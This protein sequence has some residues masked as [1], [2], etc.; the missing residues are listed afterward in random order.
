MSSGSCT[1]TP[2]PPSIKPSEHSQS[3]LRGVQIPSTATPLPPPSSSSISG[4]TATAQGSG[5]RRDS[6]GDQSIK[7][8][9][10][11]TSA[12]QAAAAAVA[13][14][15]RYCYF[16]SA[17]SAA[18]SVSRN[19]SLSRNSVYLTSP[20]QGQ[21][22]NSPNCTQPRSRP[23]NGYSDATASSSSLFLLGPHPPQIQ[24]QF[25]EN[26][27]L[28]PPSSTLNIA[29]QTTEE[30]DSEE[31]LLRRD[32]MDAVM[33]ER[34]DSG[35]GGSVS[36][37]SSLAAFGR[38]IRKVF[39]KTSAKGSIE[40]VVISDPPVLDYG[41]PQDVLDHESWAQ[42]LAQRLTLASGPDAVTAW[43]GQLS[44]EGTEETSGIAL[45]EENVSI[46][47]GSGNDSINGTLISATMM[48]VPEG[49]ASSESM[50]DMIEEVFFTIPASVPMM[51][52]P[53]VAPSP[54]ASVTELNVSRPLPPTKSATVPAP[55][56]KTLRPVLSIEQLNK[57]QPP[58]P[59]GSLVKPA[60][61]Q[62]SRSSASTS[63]FNS[64]ARKFTAA[65]FGFRKGSNSKQNETTDPKLLHETATASTTS[66][67]A[68]NGLARDGNINNV[69]LMTS[70]DEVEG[71]SYLSVKPVSK[72]T[73]RFFKSLTTSVANEMKNSSRPHEVR[74]L[75]E[76]LLSHSNLSPEEIS[77]E[78]VTASRSS[79]LRSPPLRRAAL[80]QWEQPS[81]AV[82]AV[83]TDSILAPPEPQFYSK[84]RAV[85][86]SSLGESSSCGSVE[87]TDDWDSLTQT[88][89]NHSQAQNARYNADL[90]GLQAL[91]SQPLENRPS[92]P[93]SFLTHSTNTS[94]G[95]LTLPLAPESPGSKDITVTVKSTSKKDD[96]MCHRISGVSPKVLPVS[97]KS[98]PKKS[99][100][101]MTY[102]GG[103]L[104]VVK[105]A[106]VRLCF[107]CYNHP[108]SVFLLQRQW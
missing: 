41:I 47:H 49:S 57:P 40:S 29:L 96:Y 107:V 31:V 78:I 68:T 13:P 14:Q 70:P 102:G 46:T 74:P 89:V 103:E 104:E 4:N 94:T 66:L 92:R 7:S 88:M 39:W 27:P 2:P 90:K 81:P 71:A 50:L 85:S 6:Q 105:S 10:T 25:L 87:S 5:R 64:I 45:V 9:S 30:I 19:P 80:P 59:A 98:K 93:H 8:T 61:N 43:L 84:G 24:L 101:S 38:G 97:G 76:V 54:M 55:A 82:S 58:I 77:A 34:K 23:L 33:V 63:P 79:S 32:S 3:A 67:R 44:A 26:E 56:A 12:G 22:V 86:A 51:P 1:Y 21:M 99:R 95:S 42:D 91:L 106:K 16:I 15:I 37:S 100:L 52:A 28:P 11:V 108:T 62:A 75:S 53:V 83:S 36:R 48:N 69:P 73:N 65:D 20:T 18:N 35:Y 72:R 17:A 60:M